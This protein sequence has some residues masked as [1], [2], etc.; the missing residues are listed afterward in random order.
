MSNLATPAVAAAM[1]SIAC[2]AVEVIFDK[3]HLRSNL[4][5]AIAFAMIG[6]YLLVGLIS[7]TLNLV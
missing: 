3:L 7:V 5:I 4:I 6:G 2:A 1:M